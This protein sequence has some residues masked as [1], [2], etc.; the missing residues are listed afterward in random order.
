MQFTPWKCPECGE[1]AEG[2]VETVP[3]LAL[4]VFDDTGQAEYEGNTKIH[5]NG[6]KT[7]RDES[8]NVILECPDGHQWSALH[9]CNSNIVGSSNTGVYRS[10]TQA[11]IR[12]EC[13]S[14]DR[15]YTAEFNAVP[16]FEEA[17]DRDILKLAREGWGDGWAAD[18]VAIFMADLVPD[19]QKIF[20][21]LKHYN[22]ARKERIGLTCAVNEG[23]ALTWLQAHRPQLHAAITAAAED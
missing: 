22:Q 6:Q 11:Q 15:V 8:G 2:T 16:W 5:W 7:C 19:V 18:E 10:A 1:P 13:H 17:T 20:D 3:G 23:D 21:Y 4:L 12:G 9:P 14:D